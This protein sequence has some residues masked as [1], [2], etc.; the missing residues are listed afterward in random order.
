MLKMFDPT[1]RFLEENDAFA[2]RASYERE[3]E[4]FI[5]SNLID[6]FNTVH[7][8]AAIKILKIGEIAYSSELLY[9]RV[10]RYLDETGMK[11]TRKRAV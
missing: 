7:P 9:I 2:T 1:N 8:P 3:K 11:L 10:S 4:V 5:N 6:Q